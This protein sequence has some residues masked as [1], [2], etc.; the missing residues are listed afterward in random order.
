MTQQFTGDP[1]IEIARA[2][3]RIEALVGASM[4][5]QS[6]HETRIGKLEESATKAKVYIAIGSTVA[7]S[8]IAAG[9]WLIEHWI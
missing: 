5:K 2:I 6:D 8:A 7:S 9:V 4:T 3:G 1:L